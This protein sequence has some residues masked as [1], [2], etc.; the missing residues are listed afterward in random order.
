MQ[1]LDGFDYQSVEFSAADQKN[2]MADIT[3]NKRIQI[4]DYKDNIAERQ[5]AH[6]ESIF[7]K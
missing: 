5:V 6:I 3:Q 4:I 2:T 7:S 1:R